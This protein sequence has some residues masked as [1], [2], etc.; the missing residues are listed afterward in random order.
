MDTS[1][2]EN[3]LSEYANLSDDALIAET[4][5]WAPHS[6]R[7]V[8]AKLLLESRRKKTERTRF[9]LIFWPSLVAAISAI[10]ALVY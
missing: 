2:I 10:A 4:H 3:Y 7:H 5:A 9:H 6:E 1:Q 8:A